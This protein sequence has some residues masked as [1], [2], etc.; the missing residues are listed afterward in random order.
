MTWQTFILFGIEL[1]EWDILFLVFFCTMIIYALHR[2]VGLKKV[3]EFLEMERYKVIESH[4]S[5]IWIYAVLAMIGAGICFFLVTWP[6]RIALIIPGL[7]SVL[8]VLPVLGGKKS[9][10]LRDFDF[11]KI[12]LI[13]MVWSYVTVALPVLEMGIKW[14]AS[15]WMTLF[16]RGL[17]ILAITLPFDIR[18]LQVDTH[19]KVQTIPGRIG[20][21]ATIWL[22]AIVLTFYLL[23]AICNYEV[24]FL[25]AF[26]LTYFG[27]LGLILASP[28]QE[29]DYY[30]SGLLDGTMIV[31]ALLIWWFFSISG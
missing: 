17:F 7:I 16:E 18:D 24:Y 29:N 20:I 23:L 10:R 12:F 8:Y 13:A 14:D 15:V 19:A 22:A 31:Q 28:K 3:K 25:P 2:L 11:I 30:F 4:K 1:P 27:T 5:H 9:L 21:R 6:V 26:I